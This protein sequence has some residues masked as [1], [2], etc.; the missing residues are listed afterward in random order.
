MN[1]RANS[2]QMRNKIIQKVLFEIKFSGIM[3]DINS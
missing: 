2:I 3:V 1:N